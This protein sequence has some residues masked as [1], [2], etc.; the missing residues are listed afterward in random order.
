M[1]FVVAVFVIPHFWAQFFACESFS[2]SI[3]QTCN[4]LIVPCLP[5]AVFFGE[6]HT[7]CGN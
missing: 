5:P 1:S 6:F 7:S 4:Y 3:H 2:V